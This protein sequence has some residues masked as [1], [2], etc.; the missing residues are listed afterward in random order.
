[1]ED[2]RTRIDMR[3]FYLVAF[4]L[5]EGGKIVKVR[6]D[7]DDAKKQRKIFT[8][9]TPVDYDQKLKDFRNRIAKTNVRLFIEAIRDLKKIIHEDS[10]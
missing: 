3:D 5:A 6:P 2:T 1:M 7:P 8:L 10:I 4:V 9:E